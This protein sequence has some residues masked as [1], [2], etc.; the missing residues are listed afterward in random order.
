M[1]ASPVTAKTA[2]SSV[3]FVLLFASLLLASCAAPTP[4]PATPLPSATPSA[5]QSLTPTI[6]PVVVST[7]RLVYPTLAL[8]PIRATQPPLAGVILPDEV[9]TLVLIGTDSQSPFPGRSDLIMLVFYLPRLGR[10][11]F[12]SIPPD[13]FLT[14]P[15]YTMQ[16]LN[17]AYAVGGFSMVSDAVEYNFGVRPDDYLLVHLDDFVYFIDD[18][19]GLEVTV[20]EQMPPICSDIQPGRVMLNGDQVMCY[21]RVRD[22]MNELN[23][24]LR[25]QEIL[26]LI[27]QRM[28]HGGTLARLPVLYE[29]Y[30]SSIETSLTLAE[31]VKG[32]PFLLRLGDAN[33]VGYFQIKFP[34]V[35]TWQIP[36]GLKPMVFLL[37]PASV[38]SQIQAAIDTVQ[39]PE[40][41][42]ELIVTLEY[43]L[44]I[45][46]TPTQTST[47][48]MTPTVTETPTPTTTAIPTATA[49]RT[50][51]PTVTGT[52][53]LTA[54][55]TSST[56][57]TLTP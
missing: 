53:T 28:V 44:T 40:P 45:S 47:A 51:T 57:S 16:R 8:T 32:I 22:K 3:I 17:V 43:E 26:R 2:W 15:G 20:V 10:A 52:R 42:S 36:D 24:N 18:I 21:L 4:P 33:H 19:G 39:V 25:E 11:A 1:P 46:P 37:E 9:K 48:T 6:T 41:N 49:T 14:I 55:A 12:V 29:T 23:R 30:Q 7:S 35:V 5:T 56:S 34:A 50:P 13:T 54:T 27:L 31:M 38:K